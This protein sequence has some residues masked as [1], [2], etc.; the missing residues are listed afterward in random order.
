[1]RKK[2]RDRES[3]GPTELLELCESLEGERA[4]FQA[5]HDKWRRI[6]K[7]RQ[8]TIDD[9]WVNVP[10]VKAYILAKKAALLP[11]REWYDHVEKGIDDRCP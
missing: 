3:L 6:A 1:M 2:L 5:A 9:L 10:E 7:K 8:A 11:N 4:A